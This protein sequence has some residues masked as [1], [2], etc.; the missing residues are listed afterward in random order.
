MARLIELTPV[1][2]YATAENAR[3]AVEKKIAPNECMDL[4][5]F[6]HRDEATGR[7]FPVFVGMNALAANVQFHFNI[8]A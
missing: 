3:K 2:T 6:I 7:Y 1:R 5:Y 8:V 4:T